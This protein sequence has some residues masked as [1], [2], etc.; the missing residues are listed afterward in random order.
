[1]KVLPLTCALGAELK[2]VNLADAARDDS[3]FAEIKALLLQHKVLFLRDQDISDAEH[4]AF[5]RLLM[6]A[7]VVD[8][9]AEMVPDAVGEE[10][11]GV[12]LRDGL[13]D[14]ALQDAVLDE[15]KPDL[16]VRREVDLDIRRSRL[17]PR[18]QA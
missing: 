17:R 5:A 10:D 9:D 15:E 12:A 4:A 7:D 1:M 3:L 14:R 2:N 18:A 8:L 6:A 13:V 11:G 16:T